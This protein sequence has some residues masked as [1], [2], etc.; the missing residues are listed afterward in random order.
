[1][2]DAAVEACGAPSDA[3]SEA[4]WVCLNLASGC[5]VPGSQQ[6]TTPVFE[7]LPTM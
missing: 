5:G 7:S 1:M 2:S 3:I 4:L 6:V